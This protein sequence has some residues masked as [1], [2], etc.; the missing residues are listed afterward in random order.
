MRTNKV[1][2]WLL[3]IVTITTIAF[4]PSLNNGFTN[5]SDDYHVKDNPTI[6]KLSLENTKTMFSEYF[7]GNYQPLTLLSFGITYHFWKLDARFYQATNIIFHILNTLLVFLLIYL[8]FNNPTIAIICALLFGVHTVHVESVVRIIGR[9]NMMYALFFLSSLIAYIF[10]IKNNKYRYYFFSIFLF[11][12]SVL[13][14]GMAVTLSLNVVLIDYVLKRKLISKK[15]IMEKIPFFLISLMFGIIAVVAQKS[16]GYLGDFYEIPPPLFER[17]LYSSY[18]FMQYIS[19]II[20]PIEL[21]ALYPYPQR[22]D[23]QILFHFFLYPIPVIALFG[24]TLYCIKRAPYIAF[25]VLFFIVNIFMILKL[26]APYGTSAIIADR[27][28]YIASIGI[29]FLLAL[30]YKSLLEKKAY[31]KNIL[32]IILISYIMLLSGL[33]FNRCQI[34][35]ETVI[36]D[37]VLQ[38]Y[39]DNALALHNRGNARQNDQDLKGAIADYTRTIVLVPDKPQAYFNRGHAYLKSG[40]YHKAIN[41]LNKSIAMAPYHYQTYYL[42]GKAKLKIGL[43]KE[44]RADFIKAKKLQKQ[45]P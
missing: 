13:S 5:Y 7:D 24:F 21:S 9:K 34:W 35:E 38:K 32:P 8:L 17:L 14:K 10:Y 31:L 4:L 30:G 27:Y 43:Q 37:D 16:A 36:W 18:G 12:L 19:K 1:I 41:D 6:Q 3:V 42:R 39:P 45:L 29:F 2:I 40:A 22:V 26:F 23:G 15:V 25:A 44:A 28:T 33:T 20:L 11:L